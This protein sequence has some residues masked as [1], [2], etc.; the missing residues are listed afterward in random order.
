MLHHPLALQRALRPLKRKVPA[1]GPGSWTSGRRPTGSRGSRRSRCLVPRAA[2]CLDRWLHLD[3]VHDTGPT[4]PGLAPLG[5]RTPRRPGPVGH[6]PHGHAA[7]ATADGRVRH[8]PALTDGRTVTLVVSDCMGPQWRP[9]EAG[10]RWYRTSGTGRPTCRW[11]SYSRCR[12]PVAHHGATGHA[13]PASPPVPPRP[14]RRRSRSPPTTRT[15]RAP[16]SAVPSRSLSRGRP[17][18]E[19]GGADRRS[20]RRAHTGLGGLAAAHPA[21]SAEPARPSPRWPPRPGLRFR[22][23]RVP[24]GVPPGG[25]LA[26][27]VP[28][29]P[30]MRLVQRALESTP[31]PQHLAEIILSGMLTTIPGPPGSYTF[32]RRTRS[33]PA[34]AARSRG[35]DPPVPGPGGRVDR[36]AGGTG[37]RGVPAEVRGSGA[38][39][40]RAASRRSARR[41]W[42]GSVAAGA[43]SCLAGRYG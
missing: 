9:G 42:G 12:T 30:V 31:R 39:R 34:L 36:R 2:P 38:G 37:G 24:G 20:G 5:A 33:A 23:T 3:L 14:P 21:P 32:A 19:L 7:P 25:H 15:P 27:A 40:R 18:G 6:L 16:G 8:A 29:L 35:P 28:S 41:P 17:G 43:G 4:M 22:A 1:S 10:D 11:P 13:R 26:L